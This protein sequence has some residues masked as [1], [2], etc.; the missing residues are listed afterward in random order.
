MAIITSHQPTAAGLLVTQSSCAAGGDSFQNSGKELLLID[1]TDGSDHTVTV[2]SPNTCDFG[3]AA[4][5]AHDVAAVNVVAGTKK[6]FGPFP[7]KRFN[8]SNGRVQ[9]TYSS[10][11]GMKISVIAGN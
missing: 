5:A 7:P 6:L 2:D 3:L 4:N 1:N 9:V 8:D 11:T 10:E